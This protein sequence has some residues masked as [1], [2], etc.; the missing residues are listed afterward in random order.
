[1]GGVGYV[2][3]DGSMAFGKALKYGKQENHGNM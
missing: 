1:M 3:G 2:G